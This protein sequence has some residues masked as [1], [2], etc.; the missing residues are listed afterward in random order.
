MLDGLGGVASE[1]SKPVERVRLVCGRRIGEQVLAYGCRRAEA[2]VARVER[3]MDGLDRVAERDVVADV[4][5]DVVTRKD[6][7]HEAA[8]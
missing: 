4:V 1:R 8:G 3:A 6:G 2:G 5:A 7:E